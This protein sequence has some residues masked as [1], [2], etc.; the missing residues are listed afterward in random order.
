MSLLFRFLNGVTQFWLI[1]SRGVLSNSF[2]NSVSSESLK[3]TRNLQFRGRFLSE[4]DRDAAS[5]GVILAWKI[6]LVRVPAIV[7]VSERPLEEG[8]TNLIHR[9]QYIAHELH[10][11]LF[12]RV[13]AQN[14][15][16]KSKT[17]KATFGS[18]FLGETDWPIEGKGEVHWPVMPY[19]F[20]TEPS[21]PSRSDDR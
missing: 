1:H 3:Y 9:W 11:D 2:G 8:A 13:I 7:T 6:R 17:F 16:D 12:I 18:I 5:F 20:G 4:K 21:E 10:E 15:G 19:A 14:S